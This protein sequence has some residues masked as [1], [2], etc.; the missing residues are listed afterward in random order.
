V[1]DNIP[2]RSL[3][4]PRLDESP[5]DWTTVEA[6]PVPATVRSGRLDWLTLKEG[7]NEIFDT[8][9]GRLPKFSTIKG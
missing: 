3:I 1:S 4:D 2:T 5:I 7:G 6:R 8:I 9:D